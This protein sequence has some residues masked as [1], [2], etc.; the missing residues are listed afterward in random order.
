MLRPKAAKRTVSA[1]MLVKIFM[2]M[3]NLQSY[4][5]SIWWG[6]VGQT[7]PNLQHAF[8]ARRLAQ[9]IHVTVRQIISRLVLHVR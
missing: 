3:D 9:R 8:V 4:N 1:D 7:R 2:P 5:T 6:K